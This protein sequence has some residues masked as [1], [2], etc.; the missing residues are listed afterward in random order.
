M[1]AKHSA[2]KTT[3]PATPSAKP[4]APAAPRAPRRRPLGQRAGMAM[5]R[6]GAFLIVRSRDIALTAIVLGAFVAVFD[7]SLYSARAFSFVGWSA[8]A[9]AVMP[10]ALM[11][12]SAAKMRQT[13]IAREQWKTARTWMRVSLVF[14]LVTNM[15]AAFLRNAPEAWI[16]PELLLIG[17][18][19]YHGM[20]VIFLWG[21]V[22]VLTKTRA[23]RKAHKASEAVAPIP[24]QAAE[25]APAP[26]PVVTRGFAPL[27]L[28][29][30]AGLAGMQR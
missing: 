25:A 18:I 27:D 9:F 4:K 23:D 5:R 21:A 7:G 30:L 16:T 12:I 24:A 10:D 6:I 17:A 15:V 26:I 3:T 28:S 2:R 8:I 22:E 14:S 29:R 20:V 13:G 1:T 19:A 11:V